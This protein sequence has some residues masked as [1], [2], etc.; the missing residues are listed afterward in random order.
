[1]RD[2]CPVQNIPTLLFRVEF[3]KLR[4]VCALLLAEVTSVKEHGFDRKRTKSVIMDDFT[5]RL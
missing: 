4:A 3:R 5:M 2:R 1:M